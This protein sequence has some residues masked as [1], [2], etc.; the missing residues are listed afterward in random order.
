MQ[1]QLPHPRFLPLYES[2][3]QYN[4]DALNTGYNNASEIDL[5]L[6]EDFKAAVNPTLNPTCALNPNPNPGVNRISWSC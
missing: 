5:N 4:C 1:D 2:L 3:S 6:R